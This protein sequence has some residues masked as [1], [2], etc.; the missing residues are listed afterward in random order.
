MTNNGE[1]TMY[2]AGLD[3]GGDGRFGWC[4]V[5]GPELPLE[6]VRAGCAAHAAAAVESLLDALGPSAHLH[7]AGIDSPLFWTPSGNR[8]V[9]TLVR[10]AIKRAGARNAGGTVQHVN[11][12]RGACL[13]Q[14]V[15][16]AH[17][18][19]RKFPNLPISEA[20][21]K[22]LLW[23]TNV[24]SADRRAASVTMTHLAGFIAGGV[25]GLSEHERDA[26]LGAVG[27]WAMVQ[28]PHGW[29][30]IA[31]EESDA[32]APVP[33]VEYWMPVVASPNKPLHLTSALAPCGRSARR[34]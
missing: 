33:P 4:I 34:R 14:G 19:R 5:S 23:L 20:H 30:N 13:T 25:E 27:A 32:F 17:L 24:A 15:V 10:E 3:P 18:L 7:G 21:P 2:L 26:A 12:L 22:A 16:A 28:R 31:H 9:D 29:R 8:R 1:E 6:V 11:S